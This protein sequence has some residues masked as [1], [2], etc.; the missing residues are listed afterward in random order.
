MVFPYGFKSR[1][2]HHEPLN[3]I[4]VACFFRGYGGIGRRAGFRFQWATMQVQVL[5]SAPYRVFLTKVRTLDFFVYEYFVFGAG[6][7]VPFLFLA[8]CHLITNRHTL[9]GIE[10][11]V[12][13]M[14]IGKINCADKAIMNDDLLRSVLARSLNLMNFYLI[15]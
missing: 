8:C 7:P 10:S 11:M 13:D 4:S 5:L 2:S 12:P 9:T 1:F 3:I 14:G 6:S 15:D